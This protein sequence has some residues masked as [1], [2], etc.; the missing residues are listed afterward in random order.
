MTYWNFLEP[1]LHGL[2]TVLA[3]GLVLWVVVVVP[4]RLYRMNIQPVV[5][6]LFMVVMLPVM[7]LFLWL[8]YL[9]LLAWP[10]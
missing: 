3:A 10:W 7:A 4:W 8:L 2:A 1:M 5:G 9:A 6:L